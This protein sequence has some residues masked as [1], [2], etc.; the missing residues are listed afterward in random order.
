MHV[1]YSSIHAHLYFGGNIFFNNFHVFWPLKLKI[2]DDDD[3]DGGG[4]D[5]NLDIGNEQLM[6][7]F[8]FD[9]IFF[10]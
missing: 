1:S 4:G 9:L 5:D 7:F 3:D 10:F 2:N 8:K 6:G